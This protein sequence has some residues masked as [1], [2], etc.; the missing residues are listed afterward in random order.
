[1]ICAHLEAWVEHARLA[2]LNHIGEPVHIERLAAMLVGVE[3]GSVCAGRRT[4][5]VGDGLLLRANFC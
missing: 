2:V 3:R 5:Q 4:E 1:M